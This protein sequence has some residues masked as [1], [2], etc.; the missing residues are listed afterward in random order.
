M[1]AVDKAGLNAAFDE[2]HAQLPLCIDLDGTLLKIDSLQEAAF[3]AVMT[4]PRVLGQ[5]PLWLA[6]G[7]ATLKQECAKRWTFDPAHLP[8]NEKL[9]DY[10]R[11]TRARGRRIVLVT[12]A[13]RRV[14]DLIAKHLGLFDEV[15]ASNGTDNL[16]GAAKAE[17]LCRRF[18]SKGFIYAGNDSTDHAVWQHAAAAMLVNCASN[19]RR[20]AEQR[21]PVAAVIEDRPIGTMRA[22]VKAMRPYQW[23]KNV[24]IF[25]PLLASGDFTD[26]SGWL[27]ASLIFAAF[28]AVASSIYLL[29]DISDLAADRMH[30]RNRRRPFA[31][32]ALPISIGLA[33]MPIL[34]GIGLALGWGTS[35][36]SSLLAYCVLSLSYNLKLKEMPLID[37]FVL[38]AL[39]TVRLFAGGEASDHPV[40]LWLLGFSS[41]LFLSLAL[42]KRVSELH[43]LRLEKRDGAARRGYMTADLDILQ[44]MGCAA[45]F[46]S[47]VVLSLYIQS[48]TASLAYARPTMLWGIIP[49]MLF[50]QCRLWLST[51]RGYMH[52]DPIV[53]AARDWVSWLVFACLAGLVALAYLPEAA[54]SL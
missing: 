43:R 34:L 25:V 53:Y 51:A 20:T 30:P 37:V 3:A 4:D 39:Y 26:W 52:D 8:Y 27:S 38:A 1:S 32:G 6:R 19:V 24:L 44:I 18:G 5:I 2:L 31:S 23:V 48:D 11:E 41:F 47:V 16:R 28:C 14:A 7:K 36:L 21:Y 33:L 45:A 15:I 35:A 42:V 29:N 46:A 49:L 13:D 12:A 40:S 9:L 17:T 22:A 54:F 10:L 50:W